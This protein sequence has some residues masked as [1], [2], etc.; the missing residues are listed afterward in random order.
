M[1]SK[2]PSNAELLKKKSNYILIKFPYDSGYVL[3]FKEG[4]QLLALFEYA[5][6]AK[7]NYGHELKYINEMTDELTPTIR[8]ISEK[9]YKN[10][11]LAK[12]LD[13]D[14]SILEKEDN[15]I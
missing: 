7:Y 3:P 14:L 9:T 8:P 10:A 11:K 1:T 2:R 6:H 13:M 4:S 12:L 5:E 15:E